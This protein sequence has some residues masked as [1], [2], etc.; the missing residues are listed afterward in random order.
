MPSAA[1][2]FP[3]FTIRLPDG[4][5]W[6]VEVG[7]LLGT[8]ATTL[9]ILVAAALAVRLAHVVIK[10]A[11]RTLM[12]REDGE[13]TVEEVAAA[14]LRKRQD[15]IETLAV[16]FVRFFVFVIAALMILETTF[17]LDIG[18]AIAGLGIAGIAVGLGTQHL[19]RDYLNGAL[20]LIENQYAKGDV[21]NIAGIGG[22]VEDFTLRRTTLRDLNGTVHTIPN[23]EIT[24]AS[25]LTRAW[26]RVN[27]RVQVVYGTDVARVTRV[28]DQLGLDMADDPEWGPQ[29]LEAPHVERVNELGEHGIVLLVLGKVRAASQWA[30]AG[31]FRRRLL[32]AFAE[33]GIAM[34]QGVILS[35][36]NTPTGRLPA[37]D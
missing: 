27:E 22:T 33:N 37:E 19:V 36:P 4:T 26:A 20:I 8:I 11:L 21:V 6:H 12:S 15:T 1:T 28:I 25:N 24:V 18:P 7:G 14:E 23:G 3:D 13:G 31:E 2:T 34:P 35:G 9:V 10:G 16:N 30:T 32:I 5:D 17:R 29:I